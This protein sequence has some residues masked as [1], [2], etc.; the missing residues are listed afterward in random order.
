MVVAPVVAGIRSGKIQY[1]DSTFSGDFSATISKALRSYGAKFNKQQGTFT[2]MEHDLP[3]DVLAA[4]NE[5]ADAAK[6]LHVA[7]GLRLDEIQR[8]LEGS[9]KGKK[10]DA[11]ATILKME[12]GFNKAYGEAIGKEELSDRAK[13][14]LDADY[15]NNMALW[16][17]KWS[18]DTIKELRG[19]VE[20]NAAAGYRFDHLVDR[21]QGRYDVSKTKAAFLARQETALLVS[22]HREQ[23]FGEV[24][25][26]SYIWRTAG[27]AEVREA[28]K[29][30]NG[31]EFEF[32]NPPIVDAATGRRANPGE[33]YNCRCEAEAVLPGVLTSA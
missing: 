32:A 22:K 23:R 2:I 15:A 10:V 33:D 12:K 9:V 20:E 3:M 1:V 16:I 8:G 28:H 19:A 18:S 7:L 21:I 13:R 6:N 14:N 11:T 25:I 5:Y 17:K 27:D 30:L 26:T 4:A 31:R 29:H 24:G